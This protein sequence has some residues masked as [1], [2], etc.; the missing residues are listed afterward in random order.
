M[1][2]ITIVIIPAI[3][4]R[5][6]AKSMIDGTPEIFRSL[7]PVLIAG[8]ALPQRAQQRRAIRVR[9]RGFEKMLCFLSMFG[10][11]ILVL[12]SEF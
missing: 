6:P 11:M 9:M 12:F 8:V 2:K 7:Y 4:K 5:M 10:N 1:L 3:K